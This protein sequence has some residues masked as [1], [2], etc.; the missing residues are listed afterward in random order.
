MICSSCGND[1]PRSSA[2]C[3]N[4]G[5]KLSVIRCRCGFLNSLMDSYCG[6]CG[7]QLMKTSILSR[8]QRFESSANPFPNFT[9]EELMR[10]IEV[11][12]MHTQAEQQSNAVSQSDIDKLFG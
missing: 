5:S 10:I 8:M 4:C 7:K 6:S 2:E 12:Q 1:N 11:Q 9:E 3:V